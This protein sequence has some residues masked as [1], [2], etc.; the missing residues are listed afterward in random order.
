VNKLNHRCSHWMGAVIAGALIAI[1]CIANG[2]A[3]D[4]VLELGKWYP[5]AETG[6]TL[7]QS[8]FSDNWSGGDK[9][10]VVWTAIF[11]ATL[12]SQLN[13]KVN[14]S[15]ELKLAY[16][17]TH[18]QVADANGDR[19]WQKPAKSTDLI[20]FE[21]IFRFT[22]H[23]FV[24][25]YA[26]GRFESQFQDASDPAG[27]TLSLNPVRLK[28]SAGIA[29][30]FINEED[31]SLLSRL[32]FTLR[33]NRR[34]LFEDATSKN[35]IAR[36]TNDGGIESITDYKAAILNKRVSWTSK[37]TAYQPLYYSESDIFDGLTDA[38]YEAAGLDPKTGDF[39]KT[40]DLDWENIFTSQITKLLSVNLYLRWI[41]DKYD[42]SV[43]PKLTDDGN[44]ANP[45]EVKS[46]IRKA[47]QLKQTLALGLTYRLL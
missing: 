26:S 33:Q 40:I 19:F 20:D 22:F 21:T 37:F 39:A 6:F 44:L 4:K 11:N 47:G 31:R 35:T 9:G 42:N 25:P 46:A 18:Q 14:W 29:R 10:S 45:G 36:T 41:Y 5:T 1:T 12:I 24:D 2:R 3:E 8:A 16:G 17:Q 13:D 28:E 34:R 27:R 15:N 43:P 30:Q 38:Q 7:T 23:G 32:G